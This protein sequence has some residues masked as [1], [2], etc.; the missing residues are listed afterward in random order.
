V[1]VRDSG[2]GLT[3]EGQER[4]FEPFFSSKPEGMG[5]GLPIARSIVDAHGGRL[6]AVNNTDRGAT[7]FFTL[8]A[9]SRSRAADLTVLET[10]ATSGRRRPAGAA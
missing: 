7:F 9:A 4:I 3:P 10:A 5:M 8:T 6:W 1:G 2:T